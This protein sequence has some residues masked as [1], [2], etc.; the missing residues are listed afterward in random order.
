MLQPGH[1]LQNR[2]RII[3]LLGQGGM[4][5]VYR[6][7]DNRLNVAVAI[8]EMFPQPG[9][10]PQALAGLRQQFRN[11]AQVLARLNH[12][13]LVRVTDFFEEKGNA[14]LVMN[15]VEGESLADRIARQGALPEAQV[16]NWA[17]QLLDA[18]AY[19]HN[20]GVIH[21][22]I[23]PQNIIIRRDG[24]AVLVDFGLV[25]LWNPRDPRTQTVIRGLGTP[26]YAPP[27]QYAMGAGSTDPRSDL[28]SLGATLY[29]AL[30]G[31]APPTATDRIAYPHQLPSLRALNPAVSPQTE[32]VIL[33]AMALRADQRFGSAAE[34]ARALNRP[35]QQWITLAAPERP[36][37]QPGVARRVSPSSRWL[38]IAVGLAG[39]FLLLVFFCFC[40]VPVIMPILI[41]PEWEQVVEV[42]PPTVTVRFAIS[43]PPSTPAA[44]S[45]SPQPSPLPSSPP[46]T[47]TRVPAA[48]PVPTST[49]L[50]TPSPT[51][52]AVEGVFAAIWSR[53]R[54]QLGCAMNPPHSSWMAQE[55][56]ERGQMFW[57]EDNDRIA[58]LYNNGAWALYRDIWNEGDPEYSCP[59]IAPSQCPPTPRRGFGKIWC[60]YSAVRNGLGWATDYE[61]GFNGLVQDFTQGTILQTDTGEVYILMGNN[62]WQHP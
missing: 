4:G 62:T 36:I 59:D 25:K 51:C 10:G 55:H 8:K 15:F 44:V 57:R 16:L 11:E 1:I 22:D 12:P 30:T 21:R 32:A 13:N 42:Y 54:D 2:Y 19:C 43:V 47:A 38:W 6:A 9:L 17:G 34:M 26:E 39:L 14:Y 40:V 53:Y 35:V 23:K 48:P 7:W 31:Q 37:A 52:P 29:H 60:T 3:S 61:R 41:P 49:L 50:P 20:Q 46:S 24:R 56:F 45:S 5:A 27:E 33:R 18:L 28:Y 58:V